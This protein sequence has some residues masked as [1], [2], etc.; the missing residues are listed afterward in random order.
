MPL[1]ITYMAGVVLLLRSTAMQERCRNKLYTTVA[2]GWVT[3]RFAL[4]HQLVG[5]LVIVELVERH[6]FETFA[7]KCFDIRSIKLWQSEN[8]LRKVWTSH[9]LVCFL[10]YRLA[11]RR[12]RT[13]ENETC[14]TDISVI[15]CKMWF[16]ESV[17]GRWAVSSIPITTINSCHV[18]ILFVGEL[19]AH[20]STKHAQFKTQDS[21]L[22]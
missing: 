6:L 19:W 10:V 7:T 21:S 14:E 4:P 3:S 16:S 9:Q 18:N 12:K 15:K 1:S 5:L 13:N 17:N 8:C 22:S 20:S 2:V 11:F